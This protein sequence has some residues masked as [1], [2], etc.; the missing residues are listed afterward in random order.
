M[1]S[2]QL[3]QTPQSVEAGE[4]RTVQRYR[5]QKDGEA[6]RILREGELGA[7]ADALV[8]VAE[9]LG[10]LVGGALVE[11]VGEKG[12]DLSGDGLGEFVGVFEDVDG[13]EVVG[14]PAAGEVAD[15]NAAVVAKFHIG[16]EK[17]LD[18][19]FFPGDGVGGS[20]GRHFEGDDAAFAAT[21]VT[22]EEVVVPLL[23]ES[24]AGVVGQAGGTGTEVADGRKVGGGAVGAREIPA[25]FDHPGDV[26]AAVDIDGVAEVAEILI[27][28]IPAG[29]GPLDHVNDAG[30]VAHVGIVIDGEGRPVLVKGDFLGIPET[31]VDDL[32]PAAIRLHA[33]DGTGVLVVEVA[34]FRGI[35]VVA[36]VADGEVEASV[37]SEGEAIEIVAAEAYADAIAFLKGLAGVCFEVSVG[38]LEHPDVGDAGQVDLAIGGEDA[39][40]GAIERV[41]ETVGKELGVVHPAIAIPVFENADFFCVLGV[42]LERFDGSVFLIHREA[43]GSGGEGDVIAQPML[44]ASVVFDATVEAVGLGEIEAVLFVKGDGGDVEGIRLAGVNAGLH[45]RG[46]GDG[47]KKSLVGILRGE[48]PVIGGAF[49]FFRFRFFRNCQKVVEKEGAQE[50]VTGS[51]NHDGG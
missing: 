12:A 25:A 33:E 3:S 13:T 30:L 31:G 32:E 49:D 10:E 51:E 29:V 40:G 23:S 36:P 14:V 43:F 17:S 19:G 5:F 11:A 26:V 37:G 48:L 46:I 1:L 18:E 6:L 20:C 38:V 41:I 28:A 21:V 27:A 4:D 22:D 47:G 35:E 44:V 50:E 39:G 42:I 45:F 24:G 8:L 9:E 2:G 34:S 16:I 7:L 15:V